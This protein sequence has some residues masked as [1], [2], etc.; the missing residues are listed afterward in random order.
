MAIADDGLAVHGAKESD[1]RFRPNADNF[2]SDQIQTTSTPFYFN[3]TVNHL[4]PVF[5]PTMSPQTRT[6]NP[7]L[8]AYEIGVTD[9]N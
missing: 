5:T 6:T 2:S 9:G 8:S 4:L 3:T 7:E 1:R